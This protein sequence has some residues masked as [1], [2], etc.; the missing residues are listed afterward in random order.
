MMASTMHLLQKRWPHIVTVGSSQGLRAQS[1]HFK[2]SDHAGAGADAIAARSTDFVCS[3]S[4]GRCD[5]RR[6]VR[7]AIPATSS[8]FE[9]PAIF[10]A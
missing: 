6:N 1:L 7:P 4:L 8:I 9:P 3:T 5:V 10:V 2:T